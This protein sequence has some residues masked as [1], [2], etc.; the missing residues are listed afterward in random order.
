MA[1]NVENLNEFA[2]IAPYSDEEA[3]A[4]IA[5]LAGHPYTRLISK[6]LF[7]REKGDYLSNMLKEVHTVDEFQ[8]VVM[9]KAVAWVIETTMS[10]FTYDGVEN[11]SDTSH[12]IADKRNAVFLQII[13]GQ[14]GCR[15]GRDQIV[16]HGV[17]S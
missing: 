9:S 5:K 16:T 2:G 3:A 6:Y 14:V 7:P 17:L 15:C 8:Q 12:G 11:L 1:E 10:G 4:A 13:A